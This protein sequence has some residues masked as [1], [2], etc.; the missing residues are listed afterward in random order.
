VTELFIRSRHNPLLTA[1]DWPYPAGAVFN[2]AAA[3]VGG[4]TV[5]V[6]RVEDRRGISH[7]TVARSGDGQT[8]WQVDDRPLLGPDAHGDASCWGLEDPRATFLPE[9]AAWVLAY[10]AYGLE[11]PAVAL[12]LTRDFRSVEHL[13]VVLAPEDKNASLLPHRV[14]GRFQLMHRPMSQRLGRSEVWVSGSTDLRSWTSPRPVLRARPGAWWDAARV[15]MGPP[16]LRTP[17]G[18]L[19]CYHGVKHLAGALLYRAGLV[20]LDL[21]EPWRVRHRCDD[22]VLSP[23]TGYERSGDAP[24]VVFPTGLVHDEPEDRLRLYYGAADTCVALAV[25]SYREVLEHVRSCPE[26]D[27]PA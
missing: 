26:P 9:L 13:G 21:D 23:R 3:L 6:C 22:W 11:G 19:G 24:N 18:W 20:L 12:T 25:A 10:T 4:E 17:Y 27:G 15:G 14:G 2:P 1:A 7:L 5:L 8:G 16:P